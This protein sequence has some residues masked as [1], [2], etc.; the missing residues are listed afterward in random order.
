VL[1][2]QHSACAKVDLPGT[3][4]HMTHTTQTGGQED[5]YDFLNPLAEQIALSLTEAQ[6]E[7]LRSAFAYYRHY[8]DVCVPVLPITEED[9]PNE[10]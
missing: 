8:V 2:I 7:G 5:Q 4:S 10:E 9:Q 3:V 6:V 1:G